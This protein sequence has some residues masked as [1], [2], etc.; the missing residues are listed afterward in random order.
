MGERWFLALLVVIVV[1][2]ALW[3][4]LVEPVVTAEVLLAALLGLL[5]L[6]AIA[7]VQRPTSGVLMSLFF[8]AAIV[9]EVYIY[10]TNPLS[11]ILSSISV[12]SLVGLILSFS[13]SS[14]SARTASGKVAEATTAPAKK[15][16][17]K[18]TKKKSAKKSKK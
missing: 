3:L 9:Y 6:V 14:R 17:K 1:L 13:V 18:A 7:T 5:G 11:S 2:G 8:I 4:A 12:L 16:A 15:S 10:L